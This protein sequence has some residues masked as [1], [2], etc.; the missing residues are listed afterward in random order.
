MALEKTLVGL[1]DSVLT[2]A[3]VQTDGNRATR[4]FPIVDEMLRSAQKQIILR[5]AFAVNRT[6]KDIALITGR[7]DYAIPDDTDIGKIARYCVVA[8]TDGRE[9]P[10]VNS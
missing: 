9:S 8:A 2:R 7:S 1:R 6:S 4:L 10:R 5:A 3:N